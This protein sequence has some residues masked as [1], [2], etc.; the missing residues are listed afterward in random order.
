MKNWKN[1]V[2]G[3]IL[4]VAGVVTTIPSNGD[5]TALVFLSLFAI[6]FFLAKENW[7]C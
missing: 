4:I 7:V 3:L 2:C 6:L 5:L 1:K